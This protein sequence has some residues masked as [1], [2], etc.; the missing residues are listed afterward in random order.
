[1]GFFGTSSI[2]RDQVGEEGRCGVNEEE[3]RRIRRSTSW[4]ECGS[5]PQDELGFFSS[6][7]LGEEAIKR[8]GVT[9]LYLC[10]F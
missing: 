6:S 3:E 8:A 5:F 10:E 2:S 1:M 7:L 4:Y 9:F